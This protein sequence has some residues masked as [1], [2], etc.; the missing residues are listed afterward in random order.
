MFGGTST[1]VRESGPLQ[2]VDAADTFCTLCS[3][4]SDLEMVA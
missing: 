4:P 2:L 3:P 1:I